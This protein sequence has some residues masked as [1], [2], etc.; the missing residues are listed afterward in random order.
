[1]CTT[2]QRNMAMPRLEKQIYKQEEEKIIH[3]LPVV[4]GNSPCMPDECQKWYLYSWAGTLL[5][6]LGNP[7]QHENVYIMHMQQTWPHQ[8]LFL[9]G[10]E[11]WTHIHKEPCWQILLRWYLQS[12]WMLESDL[13]TQWSHTYR[14]HCCSFHRN[15]WKCVKLF[16]QTSKHLVAMFRQFML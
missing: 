3:L 10:S 12:P 15:W 9:Y 8:I 13:G 4:T 16:V 14:S 11:H 5:G 2:K 6:L 7:D 1:M